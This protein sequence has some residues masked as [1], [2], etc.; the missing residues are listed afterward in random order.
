[1]R[2]LHQEKSQSDISPR[3]TWKLEFNAGCFGTAK[4][5]LTFVDSASN[6]KYQIL[7]TV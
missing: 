4:Y 1:M 7:I 6:S 3:D 2:F 5:S